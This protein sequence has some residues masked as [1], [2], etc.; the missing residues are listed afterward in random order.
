MNEYNISS[1]VIDF[2]IMKCADSDTWNQMNNKKD[3]PLKLI[4]NLDYNIYSKIIID[5]NIKI[6]QEILSFDIKGK[7]KELYNKLPVYKEDNHDIKMINNKYTHSTLFQAKFADVAIYLLYLNNKYKN[8]YIPNTKSYLLNNLTFDNGIPYSDNVLSKEPVFPWIISFYSENEY[9]IHPYLN[10]LIKNNYES[11]KYDMAVVFLSLIYDELLHANILI[12]SFKNKTIERFEP[13]GN[14]NM[15]ENY[16]DDT[17]EEELTWDTGFKYI[18]P[19]DYLPYTS[20]QLISNEMSPINMKP[21]DFGG[22]CLAWCLWYLETKLQNINIDSKILVEKLIKKLMKNDI[23][24]IEYIRN[25]SNDIN[26]QRIKYYKKV[27]INTK[28]ISNNYIT[29]RN[30]EKITE[31]LINNFTSLNI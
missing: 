8:L 9:N 24:P 25:Y 1:N 14:T 27:G 28:E 16:I 5:A 12:Y 21:G 18:R 23:K 17:L 20:F 26:N 15:I 10:K 11:K 29:S 22:F 30:M 13:Y 7:W 4:T 3:I 19:K 6:L 2:D 31:N